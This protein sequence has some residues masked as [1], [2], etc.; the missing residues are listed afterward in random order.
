MFYLKLLLV[1][2]PSQI[3]SQAEMMVQKI[4]SFEKTPLLNP[5]WYLRGTTVV[6]RDYD[7][8]DQVYFQDTRIV[9][10]FWIQ[11]GYTK[12]DSF[13]NDQGHTYQNI[14]NSVNEGREFV[15]YRGSG[16]GNWYPPFNVNPYNVSNNNKL[17]IIVSATCQT[18][19][20]SS[21]EE[22]AGEA[23]LRAGSLSNLKGAVAFLGTTTTDFGLANYRSAF[24]RGFFK[25]IYRDSVLILGEA[26]KAGKKQIFDSTGN[27]KEVMSWQLLGDP[28]L[29]IW[30]KPPKSFVVTYQNPI[31]VPLSFEVNV[32]ES[33]TLSPVYKARVCITHK[34]NL[35]Y[36]VGETNQNGKITFNLPQLNPCTLYL[37]VTK[38]NYLPWEGEVYVLSYEG[39]YINYHSHIIFDENGNGLINPGE[40]ITLAIGIKNTGNQPANS[41]NGKAR[42]NLPLINLTDSLAFFGNVMPDS[43]KWDLSAF[44]FHVSSSCPDGYNIPLNMIFYDSGGNF[45]N[46]SLNL[47]VNA[48]NLSPVK[49]SISDEVPIGNGNNTWEP[50]EKIKFFFY[51][52]N[53]GSQDAYNVKISLK[54]L[55]PLLYVID[56]SSFYG[57]IKAESTKVNTNDPI[58]IKS[59]IN[60]PC[61]YIFP[62]SLRISADFYSRKE[63]FSVKFGIL[64]G[65]ILH[66]FQVP[67]QMQVGGWITGIAYDG[68]GL[69]IADYYSNYLYKVDPNN[70]S[71][72]ASIPA[73]GGT[74][75]YDI[76]FD[77]L[78]QTLWVNNRG[79]DRIYRINMNG[80]IIQ[81][82]PSPAQDAAG[83]SFDGQYLWIS[84]YSTNIIYK[85]NPLN[86][87][88]VGT[89]TLPYP[90]GG[91]RGICFDKLG[92]NG[93]TLINVRIFLSGNNFDSTYVYE[94]DRVNHT[95]TGRKFKLNM[96]IRGIEYDPN[97]G[98]YWI[99]EPRLSVRGYIHKVKGFNCQP[100][101]IKEAERK[102]E[103]SSILKVYQNVYNKNLKIV[104]N[105][106]SNKNISLFLMDV[107]GRKIDEIYR[108]KINSG[109]HNFE[110]EIKKQGVYFVILKCDNQI[111]YKFIK[112]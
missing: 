52:K 98:D 17:P 41:L 19:S 43:I 35:I 72:I 71:Y 67:P 110:L 47:K 16:V 33:N 50:G 79:T 81:D 68:T 38:F 96:N 11:Y 46:F 8:S 58:I 7:E 44:S 57:N 75:V 111:T 23:W 20:M 39:P 70:G 28:E 62:C 90:G 78:T 89:Y 85:V 32:K 10:N 69:W 94:W 91:V 18:I 14:I 55:S 112:F 26:F 74:N 24:V 99:S 80:Q 1:D 4:L 63:H 101:V 84:E 77:S 51:L 40:Y 22:F 6:R 45:W 103:E 3:A 29:N 109:I 59:D 56:S 34:D 61:Y 104:L 92:Q 49:D 31:Q 76:S 54:S 95:Y 108:G 15:L 2:Y 86:G 5:N 30:T 60:T 9:R 21:G 106:N 36:L 93:G 82:F 27:T 105:L 13:R 48:I 12:I 97:T 88:I 87:S 83:L 53:F 64:P 66:T 100:V 25:K 37:T 65:T 102:E 42:I 73:P 107:S